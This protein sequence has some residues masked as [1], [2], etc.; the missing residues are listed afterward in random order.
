MCFFLHEQGCNFVSACLHVNQCVP[1]PVIVC[2]C[3]RV[4]TYQCAGGTEPAEG[5]QHGRER[6]KVNRGR[7]EK[8]SVRSIASLWSDI[9]TCSSPGRSRRL[10][11]V[12]EMARDINITR[13]RTWLRKKKGG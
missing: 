2:I 9:I 10:A 5:G 6:G 1:V 13:Y 4:D 7:G 3:N 8:H 12:W 11:R